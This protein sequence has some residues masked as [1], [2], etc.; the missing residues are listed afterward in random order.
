MR[1]SDILHTCSQ[2]L[3]RRKSRTILTVLGV[4]VG[5][6]SIV[7]MISI[8]QGINERNEQMLKSM[9]SLNVITVYAG[10]GSQGGGGYDDAV[11]SAGSS[12]EAKLN[13]DAVQSFRNIAGVSGV[14]SEK[15]LQYTTDATAGVGNRY[16][17]QYLSV[18]GVNTSQ[19]EASGYTLKSGRLPSRSGEVLVGEGTAYNF[20][21][22]PVRRGHT[23]DR[24]GRLRLRC[25][26]RMSG[27]RR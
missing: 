19:L 27:K 20:L 18:M 13:D 14:L 23:A 26:R 16:A 15:T 10:S 3:F 24:T 6:C 22:I 12:T 4:V 2:N 21:D 17:A 8:G 7:L 25:E 11:N 9:G 1:F 5:C